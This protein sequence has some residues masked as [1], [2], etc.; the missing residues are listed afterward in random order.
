MI[1]IDEFVKKENFRRLTFFIS[2]KYDFQKKLWSSG[3]SYIFDGDWAESDGEQKYP[4]LE[5]RLLIVHRKESWGAD[6]SGSLSCED[7][8]EAFK[9]FQIS[10]NDLSLSANST[11]YS[12]LKS[13]S[14]YEFKP[15]KP[16]TRKDFANL[17]SNLFIPTSKSDLLQLIKQIENRSLYSPTRKEF[18]LRT[19]KAL[20]G[21]IQ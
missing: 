5:D 13:G 7:R 15:L 10:S 1:F 9:M 14:S 16:I 8:S 12:V 4:I 21:E 11:I 6:H 2:G 19:S 18:K 3:Y 17:S 20:I